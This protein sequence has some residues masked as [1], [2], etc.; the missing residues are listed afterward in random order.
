MIEMHRVLGPP[1]AHRAQ[2]VDIAEHVGERNHRVDDPRITTAIHAGDL[3]APAVQIADDVAH[4]F[5]GRDDL[6]PHDRFEELWRRLHNAFLEGGA[7][8]DLEGEDARVDIV[9]GAVGQLG[10]QVDDREAGEDAV[11]G[12]GAQPL[13]DTRHVFPW[14]G[15]ADDL[16][17]EHKTRARRQ[18]LEMDLDPGILA[19]AAGLLLVRVIDIG[20]AGD[21]L[22]IGDLRRADIGVDLKLALHAVDDDLEVQ[23]PHALDDRLAALVI[24]RDAEGRVLGREPR[25][26]LPHLLLV[27]LGLR[28]DRDLDD[29]I[30]EFHLFQHNWL[31]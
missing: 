7:S 5:L 2:R 1:L 16:V 10:F 17:L 28:L 14:D 26:S 27:A 30:R 9:I 29:R 25:Q 12:R 31:R 24:D 23:F 21:R 20:R 4:V 11:L 13:L 8:G 18:R 22:A 15:A 3:T 6:D 19:G